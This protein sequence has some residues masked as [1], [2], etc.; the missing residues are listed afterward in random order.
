MKHSRATTFVLALAIVLAS[1][2]LSCGGS[3]SPSELPDPTVAPHP[4]NAAG[5]PYP[6]AGIGN[7]IGQIVPNLSFSGYPDSNRAGG[8]V[9]VSLADY[10]DPKATDHRLLYVTVSATWCSRCISEAAEMGTDAPIDRPQGV[11]FLEVLIAGATSGYGPSQSELDDWV[12]QK[13]TAWTVVADVRGRRMSGQLGLSG[14]P[15][16]MLIDTRTME[17]IHASAGA[18]DDLQAYV[19]QGL[20]WIAAHP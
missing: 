18:P 7:Q 19:K 13:E 10:Y 16:S 15:S 6:A 3:S 11:R 9:N 12:S 1:G 20:D 5:D 14:V 4:T 17:I 8:L 2:G